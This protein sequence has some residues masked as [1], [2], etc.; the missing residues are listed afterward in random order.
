MSEIIT[1][2]AEVILP[3]PLP[4]K[5]TYRIPQEWNELV[6]A[7]QRVAVQFGARKIYAGIIYGFTETPP[8]KYTATYILD[9]L[10]NA[11]IVSKKQIEFWEWM[12]RYY[13]CFMGDVMNAGLPAGFKLES[14]SHLVLNPDFD[15][16]EEI[17]L[18]ENEWKIIELLQKN[19]KLKIEY[20][21][22][23]LHRK[24]SIKYIN[25]LYTR[26]LIRIEEEIREKF[27]PKTEWFLKLSPVFF[28][29]ETTASEIL[30]KLER[31][32]PA[33]SDLIMAMLATGK[34]EI[35][36]KKLF[37]TYPLLNTSAINAL[38]KKQLL[39]RE[40]VQLDRIHSNHNPV[41]THFILTEEQEN[42][43]LCAR[44]AFEE[45]KK[46]VLYGVTGSGKTIVYLKLIQ[47]TLA[48]GKQ[49]L[50]L[51]PEVALT[52]FLV[53]RFESYF[54]NT[55][56]VWHH[57]YTSNERTEIY[58]KIKDNKTQILVGTRSAVFAPF[59][60]LGLIVV[61]EEHENSYKQFDKRPR[62][63]ARDAALKLAS[64]YH[65]NI[66][67]GSATP[68]YES[69]FIGRSENGV[70]LTLNNRY[71]QAKFPHVELVH[72][73]EAK[74]N[75]TTKNTFSDHLLKAIEKSL[76]QQEQVIIFQNRK[77]Y[78]P[79]ISCNMCGFTAHCPNCDITLTHYKFQ[80]NNK[81]GYCGHTEDSFH[82][83]PACGSTDI[84]MRGFGTERISEELDI[85]FPEA[86]IARFDNESIKKR[87]DFQHI[88]SGFANKQIDILVGTQLLSKGLDFENVSLV[89]V[90]DAD[91]LL[92]KPD[93]RSHE[94]AF[95]QLHQVAGRAGR[96][97]KPGTVIIQTHQFQ[98]PVLNALL[99]QN[100]FELAELEL[101]ARKLYE[102]PPYGKL[103]VILLK[104]KDEQKVKQASV[105]FKTLL[106][107]ALGERLMGPQP[108]AVAR[109][110]NLYLRQFMIKLNPAK[111][112]IAKI[113]L[114]LAAKVD[115]LRE[116]TDYRTVLIDIDVDP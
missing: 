25:S 103:I 19:K 79:F 84:T 91:I 102:Y 88:L 50:Y 96:G 39:S 95:Q 37:E 54:G 80:N 108:P 43:Y 74:R 72:M 87:S 42:A 85:L 23:Q 104:H 67:L 4:K 71:G 24:N 18:D 99:N 52:E 16:T 69:L 5:Y 6:F 107:A 63:Q 57:Y 114:F 115:E 106:S 89:G 3:L 58:H 7:G 26:G 17:E 12:S 41:E 14:T 45:D 47:D 90:V 105:Y 64:L 49:V 78:A 94:T 100:Y 81:C 61:D 83:C 93:F 44:Q 2:F 70:L 110:R 38:E 97:Q 86:R 13:M 33:Q 101:P 51:I 53:Q 35:S 77:G 66:I 40:K 20:I 31:R 32:A 8:E 34:Q 56:A 22:E 55:M 65:A 60:D 11:P 112:N 46:V 92:K 59:A 75:K 15:D 73:G 48:L 28:E 30:N 68:S 116:Q 98:H 111:D 29:D 62:F 10:D 113:K 21:N 1:L 109:L 36:Q 27:V 76:S 82:K 9:I